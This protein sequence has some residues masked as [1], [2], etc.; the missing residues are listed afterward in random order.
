MGGSEAEFPGRRFF[1]SDAIV[2]VAAVALM[3]TSN[4]VV[5]W[6]WSWGDRIASYG[7]VQT[8]RMS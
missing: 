2:L 7:P 4:R 5:H 3:L 1:L 6:F 8:R